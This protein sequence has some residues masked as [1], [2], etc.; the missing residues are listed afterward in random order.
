MQ[1]IYISC[2]PS[3]LVRDL[4]H[5]GEAGYSLQSLHA[6]EMFPQ[7][8]H[9]DNYFDNEAKTI[10]GLISGGVLFSLNNRHHH[11]TLDF[12]CDLTQYFGINY[13]KD[14]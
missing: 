1:V 7:T 14:P 3:T 4:K 6:F 12:C 2:D 11:S 13:Q 10:E 8:A 5:F 9:G